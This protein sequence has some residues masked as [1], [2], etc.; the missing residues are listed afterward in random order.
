MKDNRTELKGKAK[1]LAGLSNFLVKNKTLL[2]ILLAAIVAAIIIVGV[3]SSVSDKKINEAAAAIEQVQKD[4]DAWLAL[5]D[6]DEEKASKTAELTDR[7]D[8][9]LSGKTSAYATQR[10]LFLKANIIFQSEK[11]TDAAVLFT[12]SAEANRDSYLA[13]IAFMLAASSYENAGAFNEAL[14]IYKDVY[15]DYDRIYPD[16]P[17]A[18][19]AI[20]RLLEQTGDKDAAA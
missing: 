8:G 5:A 19:L 6:D 15:A 11:W 3:V 20:G 7:I 12:E 14:N 1:F 10:A 9:L 18:M 2:I 16:I 13:P 4:Y 17:R